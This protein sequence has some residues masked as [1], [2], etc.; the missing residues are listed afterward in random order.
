MV[1]LLT[2]AQ[3]IE[4]Q[5]SFVDLGQAQSQGVPMTLPSTFTVCRATPHDLSSV[6]TSGRNRERSSPAKHAA[7]T[8]QGPRGQQS[9]QPSQMPSL[10][11]AA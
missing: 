4:A 1:H 3:M 2:K 8:P 11:H 6:L 10:C 7:L 5:L 9:P